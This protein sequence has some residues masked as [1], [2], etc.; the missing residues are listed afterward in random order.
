VERGSAAV[1]VVIACA[2]GGERKLAEAEAGA[3]KKREQLLGV[4]WLGHHRRL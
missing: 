2:A 4:R 1:D 3:G